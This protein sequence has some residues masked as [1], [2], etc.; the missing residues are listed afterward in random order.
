MIVNAQATP[1]LAGGSDDKMVRTWDVR[2][3]GFGD[4]RHFLAGR[5]K[6]VTAIAFHPSG[7]WLASA[8]ADH[9]VRLWDVTSG[10]MRRLLLGHS[11]WVWIIGF[12]LDGQVLASVSVDGSVRIWDSHAGESRFVLR[13]LG[14][15]A[16]LRIGGVT[17][18]TAAQRAVLT[19][20]GAVDG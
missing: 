1:F 15:Y 9:T 3:V 19:V 14:P 10:E 12:S 4:M 13:P 20:L 7:T 5:E 16:G 6:E 11:H 17:G 8:G 18:I 2:A